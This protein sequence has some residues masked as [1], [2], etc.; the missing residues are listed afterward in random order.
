MP[1]K[2]CDVCEGITSSHSKQK[3]YFVNPI[4]NGGDDPFDLYY[5]KYY[6]YHL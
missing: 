4:G 1:K 6:N 5:N 2:I 3:D